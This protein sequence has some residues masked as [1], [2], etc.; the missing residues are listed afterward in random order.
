MIIDWRVFWNTCKLK[1]W[2][3]SLNANSVTYI[4]LYADACLV[5]YVMH[6][7][8]RRCTEWYSSS[9]PPLD[10]APYLPRWKFPRNLS[11][12]YPPGQ[13]TDK[14]FIYSASREINGN[15]FWA[16]LATYDG[17]GYV[18]TLGDT[19]E[20]AIAR[21]ERLRQTN[22]VDQYTRAVFMEFA[23]LNANSNLFTMVT[24]VFE[25]PPIGSAWRYQ[26]FETIK[27]Y[28]YIG[29]TGLV[30]LLLE[31]VCFLFFLTV[32]YRIIKRF[33]KEGWKLV[34]SLIGITQI[35]V[36]VAFVTAAALYT[37]RS[38]WTVSTLEEVMNNRGKSWCPW[39]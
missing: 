28:R 39:P 31:I 11:S 23:I 18:A 27:L 16:N 29:A 2:C 14:A 8:T 38:F 3:N 17:G 24:L 25:F 7:V 9:S 37:V 35:F 22:W 4:F 13:D 10:N 6:H 32:I 33:I 34:V 20:E 30:T 12:I 15:P 36:M 19:I 26:S 1:L 21:V 5:P